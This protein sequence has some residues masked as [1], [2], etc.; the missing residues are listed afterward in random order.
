MARELEMVEVELR[1]RLDERANHIKES[2]DGQ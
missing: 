2:P 1:A